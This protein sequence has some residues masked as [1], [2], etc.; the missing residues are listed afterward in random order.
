[1][2]NIDFKIELI[3]KS[4]ELDAYFQNLPQAEYV[5]EVGAN[6]LYYSIVNFIDKLRHE[7][8]VRKMELIRGLR[9]LKD[10][11]IDIKEVSM[12]SYAVTR[13]IEKK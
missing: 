4:E 8:Y 13:K 10:K 6:D 7:N 3:R 11:S 1:M 9:K 5:N 12:G 2:N